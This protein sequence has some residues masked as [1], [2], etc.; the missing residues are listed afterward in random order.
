MS[1]SNTSKGIILIISSAFC[2]ALMAVFIRLAGDI[3][4]IQKA[5]FRNAVAFIIAFAGLLL[6]Y[7][8]SGKAAVSIPKDVSSIF[9]SGQFPA[10]SVYSETF[11]PLTVLY[12]L[13]QQS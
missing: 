8:K 6:D 2:F 9:L 7:K 1:I 12:C 4:F 5:F 10:L 3:S 11:M 13:M